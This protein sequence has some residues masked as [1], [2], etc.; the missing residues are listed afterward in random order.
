[1]CLQFFVLQDTYILPIKRKNLG[2]IV[3]T[4]RPAPSNE[5]KSVWIYGPS[6][7]SAFTSH[8]SWGEK[9]SVSSLIFDCCT[10]NSHLLSVIQTK[11]EGQQS[12]CS[13]FL[14]FAFMEKEIIGNK[15]DN[16]ISSGSKVPARFLSPSSAYITEK[17]G[18]SKAAK[19]RSPP[20]PRPAS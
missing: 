9:N 17:Y 3:L 2:V 19:S 13:H 6:S 11:G 12:P 1:M 4:F 10:P 8:S 16:Q 7:R 5:V 14:H 20:I 15:G 18:D